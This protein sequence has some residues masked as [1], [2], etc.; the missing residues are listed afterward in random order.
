MPELAE[1]EFYRKQWSAAGDGRMVLRVHLH[2]NARIF[3]SIPHPA[4]L[5]DALQGAR[6]R[7]SATH[8]KNLLFRFTRNIWLTG[9]LGMSG[10][11]LAA[12]P[13]HAPQKH[14]HLVLY[15]KKTALVFR[16]PRMFGSIAVHECARPPEC[17]R[18]LPPEIL[19]AEFTVQHV[20]QN[21]Q[22]HRKSPL[23]AHLLD[24]ACYP[25]IGNWMA[26]EIL[27]R[28]R[29]SP[30][31]PAGSLG[32]AT[33]RRLHAG[34]LALCREANDI[35]GANWGDPPHNWLFPHRWKS[36]GACPRCHS[37]LNRQQL[38]GRTSCWCPRCQP[39]VEA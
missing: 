4:C 28:L 7:E 8:G 10:E 24:Q 20:A 36:G 29:L 18:V 39:Q 19:S 6:L 31:T 17:W 21:L 16:D 25:G 2:P 32:A 38:R 13:D 27:W 11:L 14:D 12:P 15:Q 34:L 30:E 23:K 26:D 35:I 22:K 9:H 5:V 3:R 37:P 1:V 33:I